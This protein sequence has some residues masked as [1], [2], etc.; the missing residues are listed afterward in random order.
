MD[1][2]RVLPIHNSISARRDTDDW[3]DYVGDCRSGDLPIH[4]A[5]A[6]SS[7]E[8]LIREL[9]LQLK[10]GRLDAAYFR[11]KFDADIRSEFAEAFDSLV[12]DGF[13]RLDG[14]TIEL[15]RQGLLRADP[16]LNRFFEKQHR[17]IRYT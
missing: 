2:K 17:N 6:A 7:R 11:D 5:L 4:R 8:L 9:I 16:L 10:T 15:T 13:A 1:H 3:E 14:D 12:A